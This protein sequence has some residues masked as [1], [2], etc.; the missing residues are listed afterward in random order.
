MSRHGLWRRRQR[1]AKINGKHATTGIRHSS[2]REPARPIREDHADQG[3][4]ARPATLSRG[5]AGPQLTESADTDD[6]TRPAARHGGHERSGLESHGY[7]HG[8]QAFAEAI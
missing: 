2:P 6:A 3:A 1:G 5:T 4:H 7:R 8:L